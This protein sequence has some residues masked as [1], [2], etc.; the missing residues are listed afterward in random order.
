MPK[1]ATQR[2]VAA[3]ELDI[4]IVGEIR[5]ETVIQHLASRGY[6]ILADDDPATRVLFGMP[7]T[8]PAADI[9]AEISPKR[10][11]IAEVKGKNISHALTQLRATAAA[12]ADRYVM[13]ECKIY[14]KYPTPPSA[15]SEFSMPGSGLGFRALR[16]FGSAYPSEWLLYEYKEHSST[17]L[18]RISGN[19]V[20]IVFGPHE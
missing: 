17:E 10:I 9:V 2:A 6:Q 8:A 19:P 11:V 1:D 14:C 13:I 5:R 16:I 7:K 15:H 20:T 4:W 12:A 3:K 18:V